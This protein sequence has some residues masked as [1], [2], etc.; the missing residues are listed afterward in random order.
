MVNNN[1]V[2]YGTRIVTE[3]AVEL[4]FFPVWWYSRGLLMV[5][6]KL[7]DLLGGI[8]Q[9]LG[10]FIWAKN[11]YRPMYGQTDWQGILISIFMRVVQVILRAIAML[12]CAA[13]CLVLLAVWL[14]L[15]PFVVYQIYFQ[16]IS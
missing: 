7:A 5:T 14:A 6:R 2:F 15:P 9:S 11:I 3:I 8:Q 4:A 13:I 1:F 12:F 10:L 16:L